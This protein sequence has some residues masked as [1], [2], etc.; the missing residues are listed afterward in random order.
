MK[1][2]L[3]IAGLSGALLVAGLF[4]SMGQSQPIAK[5]EPAAK[6]THALTATGS[7]TVKVSA[8]AARITMKIEASGQ[9][10]KS[11]RRVL[12]EQATKLKDALEGLKLGIEIRP[13][14]VEIAQANNGFG[15]GGGGFGPPGAAIPVAPPVAN[16]VPAPPMQASPPAI[17]NLIFAQEPKREPAVDPVPLNRRPPGVPANDP[18]V[19]PQPQPP[20]IGVGPGQPPIIGQAPMFRPGFQLTQGFV[21]TIKNADPVKL[22]DGANK[23]LFAAADAGVMLAVGNQNGNQFGGGGVGGLGIGGFGGPG[24]GFPFQGNVMAQNAPRVVLFRTDEKDARRKALEMAVA[25]AMAN[26]KAM[27]KG[28][29]VKILDTIAISDPPTTNAGQPIFDGMG[30][31]PADSSTGEMDVTVKVTVTCTY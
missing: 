13:M 11:A 4:T 12:D 8:D 3:G 24:I 2:F 25:D 17:D 15:I 27:A 29:D 10:M 28:G 14:P 16:P 30:G 22:I 9:D 23:V 1:W 31:M 20:G 26:A 6:G 21:A 19:P 5:A 7:G 18:A